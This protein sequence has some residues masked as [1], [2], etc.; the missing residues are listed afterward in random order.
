MTTATNAIT[1][2]K[3]VLSKGNKAED[4][5]MKTSLVTRP[6]VRL[7]IIRVEIR[8][9]VLQLR[10]ALST[11]DGFMRPSHTYRGNPV[12]LFDR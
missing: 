12:R 10:L 8:E 4:C 7:Y 3:P 11:H 9:S 6:V 2:N 1:L 5:G